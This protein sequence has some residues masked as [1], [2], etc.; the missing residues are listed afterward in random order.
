MQIH[1]SFS[2]ISKRIYTDRVIVVGRHAVTVVVKVAAATSVTFAVE[3]RGISSRRREF[4]SRCAFRGFRRKSDLTIYPKALEGWNYRNRKLCTSF[5]FPGNEGN[6][7]QTRVR[8]CHQTL[9][10]GRSNPCAMPLESYK[11]FLVSTKHP[12][13]VAII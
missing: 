1:D 2:L 5:T 4:R 6:E 9:Q 11:D 8:S 7:S 10:H 3:Q 13:G 12:I